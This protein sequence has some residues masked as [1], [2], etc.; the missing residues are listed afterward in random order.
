MKWISL[1][2]TAFFLLCVLSFGHASEL[3]KKIGESYQSGDYQQ[4]AALVRKQIETLKKNRSGAGGRT[5]SRLWQSSQFLA[6]LYAWK[7]EQLDK[8]LQVYQDLMRLRQSR[9]TREEFP[10]FEYLFI[11][12][13]YENKGHLAT[14]E[15][16]YQNF[17]SELAALKE[18]QRDDISII[19]A[20]EFAKFVNYRIDSL[21]LNKAQ[22]SDD[23]LR[24][25]T[26]KLSSLMIH[27]VAPF[28]G[29]A[30]A[31]YARYEDPAVMQNELAAYIRSSEVNLSALFFNYALLLQSAAGSIDE[32][33]EKAL[34]AF[35]ERYPDSYPALSL[36]YLFYKSYKDSAQESKADQ[37]R[38]Q[39]ETI[40]VKRGMQIIV[41]PDNR[42]SSP[43]KTW[44]TYTNYLIAGDLENAIECHVP[45]DSRYRDIFKAL[46][47]EKLKKMG[48][49]MKSIEKITQGN[50]KAEYLITRDENG[51]RIAFAIYFVNIN[52]EWKIQRY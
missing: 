41:G 25:K 3:E 19:T 14:A 39:I 28:V 47:A 49:D 36:M 11:A 51:Q 37:M 10:A 34:E 18:K 42:F 46:G 5:Y 38:K 33:S 43:E 21:H 52:G 9:T 30:F 8:A 7:L 1:I 50:Q 17:F 20:N 23:G 16:Y 31:P 2:Y 26:L 48:A 22:K 13:I 15:E 45:G 29:Y 32:G 4:T 27:H 24:L 40:A 35:I 44:E 12:Q 6:Y